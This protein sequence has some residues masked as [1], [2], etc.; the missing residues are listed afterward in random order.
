MALSPKDRPEAPLGKVLYVPRIQI[1]EP[2]S[3]SRHRKA[4]PLCELLPQALQGP[5]SF[6][7]RPSVNS[8]TCLDPLA[9]LR[10]GGGA[11]L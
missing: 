4:R 1:R 3:G 9:I 2:D 7:M 8:L 5:H 11:G 10:F 6:E